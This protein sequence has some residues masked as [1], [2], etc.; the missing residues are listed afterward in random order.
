MNLFFTLG[1]QADITSLV[2]SVIVAADS[3]DEVIPESGARGVSGVS[4]SSVTIASLAALWLSYHRKEK[5]IKIYSGIAPLSTV[6]KY[7]LYYSATFPKSWSNQTTKLFGNGTTKN[8]IGKILKLELPTPTQ[9]REF[10]GKRKRCLPPI[11]GLDFLSDSISIHLQREIIFLYNT[12]PHFRKLPLQ[13]LYREI[14]GSLSDSCQKELV[15]VIEKSSYMTFEPR[16]GICMTSDGYLV[17]TNGQVI[18]LLF[19]KNKISIFNQ[20]LANEKVYDIAKEINLTKKVNGDLAHFTPPSSAWRSIFYVGKDYEIHQ[21]Y[22]YQS[23]KHWVM[24]LYSKNLTQ[25]FTDAKAKRTLGPV[26]FRENNCYYVYYVGLDNMFHLL[27]SVEQ[28]HIWH[29]ETVPIMY[30]D[31]P[32]FVHPDAG[33][34]RREPAT[35]PQ[36]GALTTQGT[37]VSFRALVKH[38]SWQVHHLVAYPDAKISCPAG[39]PHH[40][41]VLSA[42]P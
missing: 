18:F 37:C 24:G 35:E 2:E 42:L 38:G 39:I 4:L 16:L 5:L 3:S 28:T 13:Q 27:R 1:L 10:L 29:H 17:S 31:V 19:F 41:P 25:E 6:F 9:L 15:S 30:N 22:W 14:L 33:T 21:Y 11:F 36:P 26:A 23:L 7:I 8:I 40:R 20:F 34:M 12:Q 32:I